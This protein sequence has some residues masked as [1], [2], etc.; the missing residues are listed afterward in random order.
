[1]IMPQY[2]ESREEEKRGHKQQILI[3][4]DYESGRH[5][6][7]ARLEMLG[8]YCQ[9]AG[10]GE[11]ALNAIQSEYFD[12]VITD[13][14]MPVMTGLELLQCLAERP[15]TQRTPVIFVT[16]QLSND[17]RDAA[18]RAG[19]SAILEKPYEDEE[20]MNELSYILTPQIDRHHT[21]SRHEFS[22]RLQ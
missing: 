6:L 2:K 19:A 13:H 3:V 9:E 4:D 15:E 11:E 8:Y 1:M 18:L 10:N 20:L 17:L 22:S 14:N 5:V 16:G 21:F 7:R 12:L